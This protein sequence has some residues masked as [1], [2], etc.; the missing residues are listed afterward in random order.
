MAPIRRET[1]HSAVLNGL[2]LFLLEQ[3]AVFVPTDT[4]LPL[5]SCKTCFV[6]VKNIR[7]LY[8]ALLSI[9]AIVED[10]E[11]YRVNY[12]KERGGVGT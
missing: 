7:R 1:D 6:N 12:T 8:K 11:K 2:S 4:Y 9:L 5:H 10:C 3:K